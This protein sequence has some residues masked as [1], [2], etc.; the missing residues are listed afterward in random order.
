MGR[1]DLPSEIKGQE[2][3]KAQERYLLFG[4][5]LKSDQPVKY[6]EIHYE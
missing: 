3:G 2:I 4:N 1:H 6:R 5:R